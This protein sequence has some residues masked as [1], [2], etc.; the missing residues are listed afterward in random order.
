[1]PNTPIEHVVII[2]KENHTFDNYFG[3]F[4][5]VNGVNNLPQAPDKQANDIPHDHKDWL[6]RK[7]TAVK[8]QYREADIKKYFTYAK[9]FT[10]CDNFF[11]D[12][13]GP[14]TPN[15]LMLVTADSPI[16]DNIGLSNFWQQSIP[17]YNLSSL[18]QQLRAVG[19]EW[20][21]YGGLV[22]R[23]I[24]PLLLD[25]RNV[26]SGKFEQDAL[27]GSLPEVSW[28]FPPSGFS[29]HPTES[30]LA[31]QAWTVQQINA[32]V[33]GGLWDKTAIFICWD[34]WG[35]WYDHADEPVVEL[36]KDKTQFRY[37]SRV[38]CLV[39][40]PYAKKGFI[41]KKFSSFVSIIKFCEVN[42]GLPSLNNRTNG[43]ADMMDCFNFS[44]SPLP[45][46]VQ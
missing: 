32:I 6:T 37:G 33:N 42:F 10:L 22:F 11:S 36:W 12:V 41:S 20:R 16:V 21:N 43:T 31:G 24:L 9:N 23:I 27:S 28:V 1:M 39:L 13:A 14:S 8:Q 30:V 38:P 7:T 15:H 4:P 18:P 26:S 3:R 25:K 2:V 34:D 44:Q 46:L 17:P 5:G 19:K 40:S 45:P 29:E 35:G